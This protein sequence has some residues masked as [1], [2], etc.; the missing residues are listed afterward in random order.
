MVIHE[1]RVTSYE[2][3]VTSCEFRVAGDD[4]PKSHI[5]IKIGQRFKRRMLRFMF[6]P[7][8]SKLVD[9]AGNSNCLFHFCRTISVM[10][11]NVIII[12]CVIFTLTGLLNMCFHCLFLHVFLFM[13]PLLFFNNPT[14]FDLKKISTHI[15]VECGW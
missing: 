9:V 11:Y 3:R 13:L 8:I 14:M 10:Y 4:A 12:T 5:K 1:L 7:S 6:T 15:N 2:L